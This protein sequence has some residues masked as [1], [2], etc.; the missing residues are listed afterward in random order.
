MP[1]R[2]RPAEQVGILGGTLLCNPEQWTSG[3][4]TVTTQNARDQKPVRDA[5]V[6]FRCGSETCTIGTSGP[7]GNL[8]TPLPRCLGGVIGAEAEGMHPTFAPLDTYIEGP[9]QRTLPLEPVRK[10]NVDVRKYQLKKASQGWLIDTVNNVSLK[11]DEEA[12]ITLTR[13]AGPFDAPF[14]SFAVVNG[15][16]AIEDYDQDVPLIPG[17]YKVELMTIKSADP[18]IRILPHRRCVSK[19]GKRKCFSVPQ[20]PIEFNSTNPFPAGSGSLT[21]DLSAGELDSGPQVT[22]Y[23]I[24]AALDLVPESS[25]RIEDMNIISRVSD[26][27]QEHNAILRPEVGP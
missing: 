2:Y 6:Q 8:T 5:V 25:R 19:H 1:T 23:T 20:E 27:I 10:M 7:G 4:V 22:F 26:Y 21:W 24:T 16:P 17:R 9:Q 15:D 12:I 13:E 14:T 11:P 3:T 18:A